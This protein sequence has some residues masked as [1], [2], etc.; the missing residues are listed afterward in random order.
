M[1]L[2]RQSIL[3]AEAWSRVFQVTGQ[4]AEFCDPETAL[5]SFPHR[6]V[7]RSSPL[8][9]GNE[10]CAPKKFPS[11]AEM[12]GAPQKESAD[13]FSLDTSRRPPSHKESEDLFSLDSSSR[14][15]S[16]SSHSSTLTAQ[17]AP[18]LALTMVSLPGQE[19]RRPRPRHLC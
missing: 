13:L 10:I 4:K 17:P 2:F 15:E 7:K 1:K 5:E 12:K 3:L 9:M 19:E 11:V 16:V 18:G 8:L 14:R 6:F